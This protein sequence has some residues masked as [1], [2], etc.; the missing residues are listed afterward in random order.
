MTSLTW[1]T[2]DGRRVPIWWRLATTTADDKQSR[3]DCCW[4]QSRW[5]TWPSGTSPTSS[6]VN[7]HHASHPYTPNLVVYFYQYKISWHNGVWAPIQLLG[8]YIPALYPP[9]PGKALRREAGLTP[10]GPERVGLPR[11]KIY[12]SLW[13]QRRLCDLV[14]WRVWPFLLIFICQILCQLFKESIGNEQSFWDQVFFQLRTQGYH[15]PLS[16]QTTCKTKITIVTHGKWSRIRSTAVMHDK[17]E[18][19]ATHVK[20]GKHQW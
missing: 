17:K 11:A 10:N 19:H 18:W 12:P 1:V 3:T 8:S 16:E 4:S 14:N 5:T 9:R 15:I 20:Y 6:M 2:Y 7:M 13:R